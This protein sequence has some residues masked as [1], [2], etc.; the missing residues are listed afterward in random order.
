MRAPLLA[1][2]VLLASIALCQTAD[3]R[4]TFD[5]ASIHK[6]DASHKGPPM[7]ITPAGR[8]TATTDL[9]WLLQVAYSVRFD[10]IVGGP[11]WLDGE[12]Y[13][14]VAAPPAGLPLPPDQ[15]SVNRVTEE[16]LRALLEDR[17]QLKVHRETREMPIYELTAAKGGSKLKEEPQAP[18]GQFKLGLAS[19][20]IVTRGGG[21]K[22]GMIVSLLTNQLHRPVIDKTGL[23][24]WYAF[25]LTY[26]PDESKPSDKPSLFT[27]LE[28]QLGL[29]LVAKKGSGEVLVIDRLERPSE[30]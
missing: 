12:D 15:K 29:K 9:R 22:I 21:A 7:D 19:G 23:D 30:N 28:E 17:F 27:A 5:A 20:R 3:S 24:G 14:I 6:A 10:Q 1:A 2:L 4:P 16:R 11:K 26:N 18:E 13:T 25:N 8:F